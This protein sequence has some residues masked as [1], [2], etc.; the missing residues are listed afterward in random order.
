VLGSRSACDAQQFARRSYACAVPS[1]AGH[2][3]RIRTFQKYSRL[4]APFLHDEFQAPGEHEED[5]IARGVHLPV[6][7]VC[8]L[9]AEGNQPT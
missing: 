6:S 8:V 2:D 3:K 4:G 9:V 5:L 1:A 7:P